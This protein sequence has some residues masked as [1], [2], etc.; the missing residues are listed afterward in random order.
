VLVV[1]EIAAT[2]ILLTGAGLLINS[3]TRLMQVD[4]GFD[5]DSA[6]TFRL[7]LP[8]SRYPNPQAQ[9]EF[10]RSL[11][12]ALRAVPGVE[13]AAATSYALEGD[14]IGFDDLVIDGQPR[15]GEVR[16]RFV[17]PDYFRTLGMPVR[18]GREFQDGDR[19]AGA[20]VAIVNESFARRYMGGASAVGRSGRWGNWGSFEVVGVVADST[21]RLDRNPQPTL[22]LPVAGDAPFGIPSIVLRTSNDVA[23]TLSAVRD[24]VSRSDPQLAVFNAMTLEEMIAHAAAPPRLYSFVSV[25]CAL[26]ALTL[27]AVG[28]Y[29]V[30]GYSV[31]TRTQEFGIRMALGATSGDVVA[32]VMRR[33]I[34]LSTAGIAAGLAGS[35]YLSRFLDTLLFNLTPT[36]A[37]TYAV[38]VA[39]FVAVTIAAS[40]IPSRRATRVNPV[41]ALRAE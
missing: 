29:G 33:G 25:W 13:S 7:A 36:D 10:G 15:S 17:T 31:G 1:V 19:G 5:P 18:S 32:T 8:A 27:A 22:Y 38:A 20:A 24:L 4:P 37:A 39:M 11:L 30:L 26:I 23:A 34:A 2:M 6:V 41:V 28:L 16:Y 14:P 12:A 35:F 9:H 40:Y 21:A 3:F